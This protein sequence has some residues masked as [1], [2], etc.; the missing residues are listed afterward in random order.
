MKKAL[1][2]LIISLGLVG[3]WQ[4]V[5]DVYPMDFYLMDNIESPDQQ[6]LIGYYRFTNPYKKA[7]SDENF[8]DEENYELVINGKTYYPDLEL[9]NTIFAPAIEQGDFK[10]SD[11]LTKIP[12]HNS[13]DVL[14]SYLID[15][16]SKIEGTVNLKYGKECSSLYTLVQEEFKQVQSID[17]LIKEINDRQN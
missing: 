12:S 16:S 3:C 9:L 4:N 13:Y 10:D 15:K 5:F 7:V 1:M 11:E 17:E 14:I 2:V 8:S 6:Y